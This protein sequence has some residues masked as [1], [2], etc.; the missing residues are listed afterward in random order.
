MRRRGPRPTCPSLKG[1]GLRGTRTFARV[2][3]LLWFVTRPLASLPGP[4]MVD[5]SLRIGETLTRRYLLS[6]RER[7]HELAYELLTLDDA[8]QEVL[9]IHYGDGSEVVI[10]HRRQGLRIGRCGRNHLL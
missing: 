10:R 7:Q 4:K 6:R 1:V 8:S 9:I 2:L 5:P 3:I